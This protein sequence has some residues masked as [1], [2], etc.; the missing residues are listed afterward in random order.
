MPRPGRVYLIGGGPGD[1]GLLTIRAAKSLSRCDVVLYD[2]L[3][4]TA[5]LDHAPGAEAINVG[6]HGGPRIWKQDE[7]I[8]EILRHARLGKTVGRLKGGDPAV[9]ARTSE[10]VDACVDA[11]IDFEI[12]PGITAA[13]AA[14]S[15]AGIPVTHRDHASAVALVTGH[16][17]PGKIQSAID[18]NALAVFPGTLV[19]YMGV[20]TARSWTG[21]LIT[22][23]KDPATPTAIIRRCSH[24]DQQQIHCRLD[25]V[26]DHLTPASKFRPPVITIVGG[27]TQLADTMHWLRRRPL[28]GRTVLVT[29]PVDHADETADAFH[30]AGARVLTAPMIQIGPVDDPTDLDVAIQ[31]LPNTD[32][33]IFA[34]RNG[35][36]FFFE[37]LRHGGH[38]SRSL[39]AIVGAIGPSTA[40]ALRTEGISP[41][42]VPDAADAEAFLHQFATKASGR[43]VLIVRASRGSDTLPHGLTDAGAFVRQTI[44]YRHRDADSIDTRII[45]ELRDGHVDWIT[46]T[47]SATAANLVG[48]LGGDLGRARLAAISDNV[49]DVFRRS[50]HAV[51]AV[52]DEPSVEAMIQAVAR[53]DGKSG[54]ESQG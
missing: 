7:I 42:W 31:D 40:A 12:V 39:P 21:A 18:W 20:T 26:A 22:A 3:S 13:L 28:F 4:N 29:R 10:E 44:A 34:S 19:I 8:A 51:A 52:A 38:D 24:V 33:V 5:I 1:P 53:A 11:G 36:R 9:F 37:R 30:D 43:S 23:G 45:D 50:G 17:Q 32:A 14:G 49:A 35:V 25:E 2:G 46:A 6:K 27:V 15:Y 54:G 41:D 47:S 48:L 16:E